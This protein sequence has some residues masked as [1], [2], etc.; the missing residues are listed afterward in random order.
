VKR[1]ADLAAETRS[2]LEHYAADVRSGAFPG[3]EHTYSIPEEELAAFE[4]ALVEIE[5]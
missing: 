3:D 2:A 5:P 4:A 1:Y